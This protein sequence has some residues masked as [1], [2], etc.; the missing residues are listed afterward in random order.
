MLDFYLHWY[1]SQGLA[2]VSSVV[3]KDQFLK[4][5]LCLRERD[6]SYNSGGSKTITREGTECEQ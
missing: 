4:V 3:K 1:L 2:H 5:N 6:F